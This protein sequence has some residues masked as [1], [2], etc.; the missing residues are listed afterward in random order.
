VNA[1][2]IKRRAGHR[3]ESGFALAVSAC[4]ERVRRGLWRN[5]GTIVSEATV[6]V[7]AEGVLIGSLDAAYAER[8]QAGDRFVLDGRS[9]EFRQLDGSLVVARASAGEPYLPKWLSDRQGLSPELARDAARFR[10]EAA[11]LLLIDGPQALRDWLAREYDLSEDAAGL[12]EDLVHAQQQVSEVP[13]VDT[14][15]VEEFPHAHGFAY[16]FHAPL[17]RSACEALGRATASRLGRKFGRN[18]SLAVADLGWLIRLPADNQIGA[19]DLPDL[20]APDGFPEAVLEGLDRGDL[21]AR[22][23]RHVASTAL[24]VLRNPDGPRRR[25]GGLLWVSQRLYPMLKAACPDH[26]LLRETRREVLADLL[27]APGAEDWLASRPA[28]RFRELSAASPFATAWI[29]PE[30]GEA[31][32]FESAAQALKRLHVRL[33]SQNS[34][35]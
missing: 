24:M 22:R 35:R 7:V 8:L 28:L 19:H 14:L 29:D 9:F 15:L 5:G 17:S 31:V 4:T 26:P 13:R 6:S 32:R 27:D 2:A 23:F 33:M 11:R 20:L 10:E 12:L 30:H 3:R 16:A 18:I 34:A 25:V 21:L 1:R